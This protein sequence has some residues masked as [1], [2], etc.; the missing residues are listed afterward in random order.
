MLSSE[1][2]VS[3]MSFQAWA[4]QW[5][6]VDQRLVP[7]AELCVTSSEVLNFSE[8]QVLPW[9]MATALSGLVMANEST[10][11]QGLAH[12]RFFVLEAAGIIGVRGGER[13]TVGASRSLSWEEYLWGFVP[14]KAFV[15]WAIAGVLATVSGSWALGQEPC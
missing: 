10:F 6:E 4:R 15:L 1:A 7:A 13:V 14:L 9:E 2:G 5:G 3:Q 12:S 11:L 8:L